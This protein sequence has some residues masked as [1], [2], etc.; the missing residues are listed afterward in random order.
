MLFVNVWILLIHKIRV[1]NKN[2]MVDCREGKPRG[3]YVLPGE[4]VLIRI[5]A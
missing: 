1:A 5:T 4:R 3:I 2:K